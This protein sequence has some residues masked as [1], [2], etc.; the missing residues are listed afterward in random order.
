MKFKYLIILITIG[1]LLALY[2]LTFLSQPIFVRLSSIQTFTGQQ[3]IVQGVV[4]EYRTTT[5]GT[6]LI[7]IREVQNST[8]SVI[9]YLEGEVAIEY[10]DTVQ[11]TGEVQQYKNQWEIVVN[12]PQTI[13]ILQ[14]WHALSFPL[15]QL[16]LHP[17]NYCDT[18]VNVTGIISQIGLSSCIL[19]STDGEYSIDVLYQSSCPHDI[20][21]GDT[22][23][24]GA[25]FLYDPSTCRFCLKATEANHGIWKREG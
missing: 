7:T 5:Y 10:G 9:V 18:T 6:Q 11:V 16:A 4:T 8:N 21:K 3:V 12:D 2:L 15:W 19:A 24:V 14:K 23:T 25:R 13:I 22:V 20:S 17:E 1:S